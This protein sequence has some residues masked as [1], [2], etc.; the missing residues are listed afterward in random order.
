[1]AVV[2]GCTVQDANAYIGYQSGAGLNAVVVD[3]SN[4]VWESS[5]NV[6][7]GNAGDANALTIQNGGFVENAA[8]IIGR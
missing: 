6:Y 3:G 8:G 4:A 7:V 1:M 2:N 5:G